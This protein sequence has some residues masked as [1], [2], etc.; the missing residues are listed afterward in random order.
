MPITRIAYA[1]GFASVR[2]FNETIQQIYQIT[3]TELRRSSEAPDGSLLLALQYRGPLAHH[4]L[5]AFLAE[6]AIPGVE[7]VTGTS[8]RRG[9]PFGRTSAI[10][11]LR[12]TPEAVLLSVET[13]EVGHLAPVIQ[14]ARQLLD[15][16]ADPEVIDGHLTRSPELRPLVSQR[17][18]L[19]LAGAYNSF[20]TAVHAILAQ[21]TSARAAA[22]LAGR[23]AE[24]HGPAL[25]RPTGM[26]THLFPEPGQLL[27]VD[28]ED[29]GLSTRQARTVTAL[30]TAIDVG[31]VAIDGSLDPAEASRRL[32]TIPGIGLSTATIIASRA[33]RD[34]DAFPV[35]PAAVRDALARF[36]PGDRSVDCMFERWRPWRGYAAMH[37]S[38]AY[39]AAA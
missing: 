2:A 9:I 18:G 11:E 4:E 24:R 19:R 34:P 38:A 30:A 23:V 27:G 16:D 8:Y 35:P 31:A 28:L 20:E 32:L 7:Q 17:P 10:I 29:I 25:I 5:F 3:P 33:L 36:D 26:L 21:R 6:R 14:R 13:D 37:V 1:A 39:G 12:P 15:L 22:D